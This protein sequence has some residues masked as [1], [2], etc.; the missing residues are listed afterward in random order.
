VN[1]PRHLS[2][3]PL[4]LQCAAFLIMVILSGFYLMATEGL[5]IQH[6]DFQSLRSGKA[7][8]SG[9][10][11]YVSAKGRI[12]TINRWDLNLD[13]ELD[14]LFTQ[15]HNNVYAPDSLLY[16][17]G[18]NG[19]QSLLPENWKL[20]AP[21]SILTHIESA[22]KKITRFP[23][24]GGGRSKIAD[25]NLDGFPEIVICNSQHNY[26]TDQ[27][28]YIYWGGP[29]GYDL[30]KKTELPA[31]L[32]FGIAIGDLDNDNLP[33]IVL[34]NNGSERGE[35]VEFKQHL[36][37][38][39]YWGNLNG[40]SSEHRS[41]IPTISA[42]DVAI[43]DYNGD[44]QL[45]LAFL[46]H[47]SQEES[48]FLYWGTG[49]R[50]F[51]EQKRQVLNSQDLQT[52]ERPK[53][54]LGT[55]Q[56][57]KTLLTIQV[58]QD[59]IADLVVAG[60][61]K[62]ILFYG[63]NNGLLLDNIM[64]LP[65]NYCQDLKAADLNNDKQIDLVVANS[66]DPNNSS[67]N[68]TIYW[69]TDNGFSQNRKTDLPSLGAT[70]VSIADL[71]KD[72]ILDIL[73]GNSH[74]SIG[75]DVPSYIYWGGN[76]GF[77]SHRRS[78]LTGFGTIS[79]GIADLNQDKHPDILLVAHLSGKRGVLPSV[80]YWGTSDHYYSNAASTELDLGA[81]MEFSIADL[82]D[83]NFPDIIFNSGNTAYVKWGS[84]A[85]YQ[86]KSKETALPLKKTIA[87]SVADLNK[88]GFLDIVF[89]L[90]ASPGGNAGAAIVWGNANRFKDPKVNKWILNF[91]GIESNA[92]ADLNKD[93]FLDLIFPG[94][95]AEISEIFWGSPQSYS[96]DNVLRLKTNGT[97]HAVP[98]DL[99][100][101]GWLD[102]IFASGFSKANYTTHTNTQIYWGGPQGFSSSATEFEG[103]TTL[104][105]SVADFNKDGHL[106]IAT[107]NYRSDTNRELPAFIYWGGMNRDFSEKRRQ[108]LD[109]HS[110]AAVDS[111][112]LN[113]DGWT[114][115]IISNHQIH[116]DHA[117]GTNIY[118]GGP[119]GFSNQ[120]RQH[121]PTIGVH[122]DAMVDAGH[123]YDRSYDWSY[124]SA[125]VQ[126]SEGT[127][128]SKL[129]W[130]AIT[131]YGTS[132]KFQV[133]SAKSK[134]ELNNAPW[135]GPS[136]PDSFHLESG[137]SL[138]SISITHRWLQYR[139]ILGSPDGGNSPILTEVAIECSY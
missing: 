32:A 110:S 79:S 35:S 78:E 66:G 127:I 80:I 77:A 108:L 135:T 9:A 106:D 18:P 95:N 1:R 40:Y 131:K 99:D 8:D 19:F 62:A 115:L 52:G 126:A 97:P 76:S 12:Q 130:D 58:N 137:E 120:D 45:D 113:R 100:K 116:F 5:W 82:D 122:L 128:F 136:G 117:A 2:K 55:R 3:R 133:R 139:A 85:G 27:P 94:G 28:A 89:S 81:F 138:S 34:A 24:S 20:R 4:L 48:I 91:P 125:P 105:A 71:N 43:G 39:I 107:T 22:S 59:N 134:E 87:S 70:T 14:L 31:L 47:N 10:N 75:N 121:I 50:E 42:T 23:T 104:D 65:T 41:S 132:V 44:K 92:I 69:G 37:S 98:A 124:F 25:L 103:F 86:E 53:G 118:W 51:N 68:S 6:N 123:V 26:R 112:D 93:G 60:S 30:T 96:P 38:Y 29:N 13:G 64:T 111:L 102:L 56:G 15:D 49:K 11:L 54:W 36:E 17:G 88:D 7:D 129:H 61:N 57:M 90:Q 119:K 73:I 67:T 114:D 84:S 74:N 101:D 63:S 109:A 33:D 16:W 21:F 72:N 83:D 46:N